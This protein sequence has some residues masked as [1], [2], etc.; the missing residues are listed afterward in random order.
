MSRRRGRVRIST[1]SR[2]FASFSRRYVYQT[3][4]M[5][6]IFFVDPDIAKDHDLDTIRD[7]TLSY[8]FYASAKQ[9]S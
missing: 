8:T 5:P 1:R 7:I 9:G 4:Q 2:C 6:V 3:V